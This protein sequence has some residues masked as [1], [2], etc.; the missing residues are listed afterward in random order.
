MKEKL[1]PFLRCPLCHGVL[2]CNAT[3]IVRDFQWQEVME[4]ELACRQCEERFPVRNGIPRFLSNDVQKS[5]AQQTVDGFGYEWSKFNKQISSSYM[6]QRDNFIDYIYPKDEAF[7]LDKT[8]LDAGCGMGRYLKLGAEFGSREIIGVDLSNSVEA[9]YLNTRHLPN[10]HV[11]QGDILAPPFAPCFDYILT[12]GVLQFL[13]QPQSGFRKL[14]NLLK[15]GGCI[16]LWVYAKENNSLIIRMISPIRTHI[17]SRL[18]HAVLYFFSRIIGATLF[19]V[20]NLVYKPANEWKALKPLGQLLPKN[21]YLYYTSRLSFHEITSIVFDHLVPR[22]TVY[23]S[24][25][26]IAQWFEQEQFSQVEISSRRQYSWRAHG[27]L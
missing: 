11:V 10:A 16:S 7:F 21:D 1:V 19:A 3:S 9:A 15:P 13:P 23:L 26:E 5:K 6:S 17:T 18:P 14:A 25:S 2:D 24:R 12:I 4:G 20:L 22:L 8:I 27:T